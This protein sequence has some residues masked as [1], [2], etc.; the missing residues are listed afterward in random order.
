MSSL[1]LPAVRPDRPAWNKGSIG[2]EHPLLP[3]HVSS[4]R[5]RLAIA[6]NKRDLALL[7]ARRIRRRRRVCSTGSCSRI[8]HSLAI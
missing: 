3:W 8:Y 5:V 6:D 1:F 4:I 2:Q 7:S